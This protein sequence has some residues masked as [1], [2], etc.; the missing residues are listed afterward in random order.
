MQIIVSVYRKFGFE[1]ID[2]L[3]RFVSEK[4]YNEKILNDNI[5]ISG[6]LI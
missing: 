4:S 5:I 1:F 3:A 6:D 2:N